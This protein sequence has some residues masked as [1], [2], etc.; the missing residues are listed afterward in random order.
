VA[1]LMLAADR[2][3]VL[4]SPAF[5][6]PGPLP[7]NARWVGAVTDP[8]LPPPSRATG[9]DAHKSVLVSLSTTFQRQGPTLER[10]I[11]AL[12]ELPVRAVVTSGPAVDPS[13]LPT[14][15]NVQIVRSVPHHELLPTTDLVITHGGH[16]TVSTALRHGVPVLC[17]PFGRDQREIAA[18]VEW[19]GVG[20]GTGA[21]TSV[22]RLRRLIRQA[23]DD[24]SLRVGAERLAM[25]MAGDD[26]DSAVHELEM[27]ATTVDH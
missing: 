21:G 12:G 4:T 14:A 23:L 25:R 8:D 9:D 5:D 26:P 6:Y 17:L 15:P 18:R 10:I 22:T 13:D 7:A 20:I 19:H 11:E 1:E 27:I 16:G 24:P 2:M 3:L